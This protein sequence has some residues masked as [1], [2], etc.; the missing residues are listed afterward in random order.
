MQ[1]I[2]IDGIVFR[3]YEH[4]SRDDMKGYIL[5]CT[6]MN[7]FPIPDESAVDFMYGD[8]ENEKNRI[9]LGAFL[10]DGMAG[11]VCLVPQ[12]E[13][14]AL[15]CQFAV[16]TKLQGKGIGRK[17]LAYTHAAAKELGFTRIVLDAR[18]HAVGFYA[19]SGY[20]PTGEKKVYPN[21]VLEQMVID[22]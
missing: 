20:I 22:L 16:S 11:T 2:E 7:L 3:P 10:G 13:K 14:T 8:H 9:K 21:L 1:P 5:R 18:Q 6:A 15:L 19:K 12:D 4:G 17:L